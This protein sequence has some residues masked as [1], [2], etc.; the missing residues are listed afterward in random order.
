MA[1][2]P[3]RPPQQVGDNAPPPVAM[4]VP[5]PPQDVPR[6]PGIDNPNPPVVQNQPH[7]P[8]LEVII[9]YSPPGSRCSCILV[10]ARVWRVILLNI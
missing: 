6:P 5:V 10:P 2:R 7:E 9:C 8:N 3:I 4:D 1:Q